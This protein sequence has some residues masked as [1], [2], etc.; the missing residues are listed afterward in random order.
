MQIIFISDCGTNIDLMIHHSTCVACGGKEFYK[1]LDL[2]R[3][4]N[5]NG[6]ILEK[7]LNKVENWTLNFYWCIHCGMFQ[8]L[9]LVDQKKLFNRDYTYQTGINVPAVVHFNAYLLSF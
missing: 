7:D 5:A 6:L 4:P 2:G 3:M 9:N 1:A 8:Q